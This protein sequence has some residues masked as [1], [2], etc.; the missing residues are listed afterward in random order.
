M[1][2]PREDIERYGRN[3]PPLDQITNSDD[4]GESELEVEMV[5]VRKKRAREPSPG[6]E[7]EDSE[8]SDSGLEKDNEVEGD[9]FTIEFSV[10]YHGAN[11]TLIVESDISWAEFI[12]NLANIMSV[13]PR[14]VSVAYRFT[15]DTRTSPF[16]HLNK[17]IHLI[18]L[19]RQAR[20]AKAK[21][22]KSRSQKEFVVELKCL[23]N[24]LGNSMKSVS[25]GKLKKPKKKK[26]KK[27]SDSEIEKSSSGDEVVTVDGKKV[28]SSGKKSGPQWVA[29]L[30]H[31]N[32]CQEHP[33]SA[34]VKLTTV[35]VFDGV[36]DML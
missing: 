13:S 31:D 20:V 19:I 35:P 9:T 1:K 29:Q 16:K 10:P 2:I 8:D 33:G 21:L 12:S 6:H 30:E 3:L 34:C 28:K 27:E 25:E 32:A 26:V 14:N 17:N 4:D 36:L 15:T 5:K 7:D 11:E 24:G 22:G 18:E 23:D